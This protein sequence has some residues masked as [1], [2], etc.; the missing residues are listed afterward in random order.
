MAKIRKWIAECDQDHPQCHLIISG[1]PLESKQILAT[2]ILDVQDFP[3]S[4]HLVKTEGLCANYV[5]LSHCWGGHSHGSTTKSTL[6]QHQR[7]IEFLALS[8]TVQDAIQT[9]V[10]IGYSYLWI[11]SLCIIQDDLKD[12]EI[13]SVKMAA[14]YEN[15]V[16]T[17]AATAAVDGTEGCF[18]SATSQ[19]L[20]SLPYHQPEAGK[21]YLGISRGDLRD[22]ICQGPLNRRGWVLQERLFSRR[23][24]HFAADQMYWECPARFVG[25]DGSNVDMAYSPYMSPTRAL[26]LFMVKESRESRDHT[27]SSLSEWHVHRVWAR[28]VRFYTRCQLSRGSDKLAAIRSLEV[29]ISR[30]NGLPFHVGHCFDD[31]WLTLSGLLWHA[32]MDD[33]LSK[34]AEYRAPSWSWASVDGSIDF[35]EIFENVFLLGKTP[36]ELALRSIEVHEYIHIDGSSRKALHAQGISLE[37]ILSEPFTTS[38]ERRTIAIRR[39]DYSLPAIQHLQRIDTSEVITA[40]C[41]LEFDLVGYQYQKLWFIPFYEQVHIGG[42]WQPFYFTL[43]V[44]RVKGHSLGVSV[45]ERLGIGR[46]YDL[47]TF[48]PLKSESLVLI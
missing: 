2:R 29:E 22:N 35:C 24:I 13:E 40:Q 28:L 19:D 39:C 34:A 5:A 25:D 38:R 32:G 44:A 41:K 9:T 8:K 21:V 48:A 20:V 15:A 47:N 10:S 6:S 7:H 37:V 18:R 43:L 3:N 26:L 27:Y 1:E 4:L 17:I 42:N 31:T 16:C 23:I 11:D 46:V 30:I 14:L 33:C 45:Y 36:T 12:F